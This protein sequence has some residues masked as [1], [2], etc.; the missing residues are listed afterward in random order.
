MGE[1][2]D[3]R[4]TAGGHKGPHHSRPYATLD[5]VPKTLLLKGVR[6]RDKSGPYARAIASLGLLLFAKNE[7]HS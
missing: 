3:T 1:M 2:K 5:D 4:G 6:E 7:T